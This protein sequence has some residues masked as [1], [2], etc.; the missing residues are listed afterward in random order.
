MS[1]RGSKPVRV[2]KTATPEGETLAGARD[3]AAP[4]VVE[5][6]P[7]SDMRNAAHV[8]TERRSRKRSGATKLEDAAEDASANGRPR[9]KRSRVAKTATADTASLAHAVNDA[10]AAAVESAA[11]V[12]HGAA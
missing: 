4:A 10:A 5:E 12:A 8:V 3:D 6:T 2:A 1:R 7:A 9:R 11:A